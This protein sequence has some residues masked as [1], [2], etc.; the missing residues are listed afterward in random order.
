MQIS[1]SLGSL[2]GFVQLAVYAWIS[3][4]YKKTT[5]KDEDLPAKPTNEVQLSDV[6]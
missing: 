1:N 5:P 3:L 6:V 2:A 4:F